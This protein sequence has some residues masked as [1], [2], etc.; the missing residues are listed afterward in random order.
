MTRLLRLLPVLLIAFSTMAIRP[1]TAAR[2]ACFGLVTCYSNLPKHQYA[3]PSWRY[4][5]ACCDLDNHTTVWYVYID[6]LNHW[7]LCGTT[8]LP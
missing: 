2:P 4:S 5:H 3:D 1:A 8:I 7:H 6:S